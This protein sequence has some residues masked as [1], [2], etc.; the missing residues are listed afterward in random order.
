M[1][2]FRVCTPFL[3]EHPITVVC[4]LADPIPFTITPQ[5][6]TPP[7]GDAYIWADCGGSAEVTYIGK[8]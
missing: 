4:E 3:A 6:L 7:A 5:T 2:Y 8:A 1:V